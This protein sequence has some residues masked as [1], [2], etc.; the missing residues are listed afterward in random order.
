MD[1]VQ[2]H[3]FRICRGEKLKDLSWK[4]IEDHKYEE[5]A[6]PTMNE[7]CDLHSVFSMNPQNFIKMINI[8]IYIKN[9]SRKP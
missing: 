7:L 4:E 9:N 2:K 1:L 3:Y 8:R 6:I 5:E